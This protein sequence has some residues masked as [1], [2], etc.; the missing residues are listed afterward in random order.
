VPARANANS[1]VSDRSSPNRIDGRRSKDRLIR[2]AGKLL[3]ERKSFTLS[4]VADRA[5]VSTTTA[6]RYFQSAEDASDA[7]VAGF[8]D[9]FEQRHTRAASSSD[10]EPLATVCR[11][12]IDAVLEWGPALIHLRSPDGFLERLR[13]GDAALARVASI[14]RPAI[15]STADSIGITFDGVALD[16]VL[17][18]WNALSDPREVLDQRDALKWGSEQIG[19]RLTSAVTGTI[20]SFAK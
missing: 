20:Q 2:A 16:Y 11:V 13:I 10:A 3:A 7:Y 5:G 1:G 19:T 14:V 18:V 17:G 8:L 6:Y 4:D 15:Q 9:D 12:W